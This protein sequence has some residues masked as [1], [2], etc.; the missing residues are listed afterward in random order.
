MHGGARRG[1]L[2]FSA[3]L[4]PCGT[5]PE[6]RAA[7]AAASYA[8]YAD[9]DAT[10][11]ARHL[12]ADAAVAEAAVLLTAGATEGLR[13]ACASALRRG[14]RALVAAPTYGEYARAAALAGAEVTEWRPDPPW[15]AHDVEEL[16]RTANQLGA[17]ALFLCDPNNPTG[18]QL[19]A[20]ALGALLER[21]RGLLVLDQSFLP[22][23]EPTVSAA[24][25]V[26]A[27]VIV[28]RSLTKRLATPGVRV[29]YV[30][31]GSS[32]IAAM[33][34]L[35]DPWSVGAHAIAAAGAARFV[36]ADTEHALIRRWRAAL[37]GGLRARGLD[38]LESHANFLLVGLDADADA[39]AAELGA[40]NVA[41][42]S[43]ASF[44][45]PRHL[46]FAV[47]APED[48]AR[49]FAALDALQRGGSEG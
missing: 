40:S 23:G 6:V 32:R 47:R 42:R 38:P 33:R 12:A 30:L 3:N 20:A 13:L 15:H 36:I 44:R 9:L 7:I 17:A 48:Q 43:G 37:V 8:T 49:L 10:A 26:R 46:R 18:A 2:E 16:A 19:D 28:L 5:P 4:N 34:A 14:D 21:F 35:Q 1:Q 25:L 22:F 45:L 39:T 29:G 41:V 24:D 31:A 27:D 11:A